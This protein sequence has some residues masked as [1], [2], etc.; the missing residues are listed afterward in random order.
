MNQTQTFYDQRVAIKFK[1]DIPLKFTAP[2]HFAYQQIAQVAKPGMKLLDLGCGTGLH[3]AFFQSLQ[4]E[5]TGVDLSQKSLEICRQQLKTLNNTTLIQ[6]DI[7]SF[8]STQTETYDIIF[9]SGTLYYLNLD[10]TV[11][12][13]HKLLRA[14][15]LFVCIDTNG[16]NYV[17]NTYRKLKALFFKHRDLQTQNHLLTH[18]KITTHM[19]NVF[20]NKVIYY[21]DFLTIYLSPLGN[22]KPIYKILH[23]L[24]SKVFTKLFFKKFC[25]KFVIIAKKDT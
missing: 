3:I 1:S 19:T 10:F 7:E 21:F 24:D 8:L 2:Y 18:K 20:S 5:V 23:Y 22:L 4:L 17:L 25:F 11:P 9:I 15:G 6:S 13:I 16:D 14:N 12:K